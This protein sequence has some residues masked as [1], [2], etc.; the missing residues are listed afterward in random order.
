MKTDE[1]LDKLPYCGGPAKP[2][3]VRLEGDGFQREVLEKLA[4]L[5]AKM[6]MLVGGSQ[7]GRV[8]MI[9]DRVTT[10][11]R[12]DVRRSVYDRLLSAAIAFIVSAVIAMR[13][14]LGIR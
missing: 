12:N 1:V 5:E 6:D 2:L 14:H 9:E 10:L 13:E 11:E 8:R 7:P 3:V 4:R